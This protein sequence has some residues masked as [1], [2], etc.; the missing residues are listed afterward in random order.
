MQTGFVT[1]ILVG[2]ATAQ[3]NAY[4]GCSMELKDLF[5]TMYISVKKG[6]YSVSKVVIKANGGEAIARE[7]TVDVDDWSTSAS[8]TDDHCNTAHPH[9]LFTGNTTDT[10]YDRPCDPLARVHCDHLRFK[11]E[12]IALI[13]KTEP[14]TLEAGG[15]LDTDLMAGL[16]EPVDLLGIDCRTVQL[17]V[18]RFEHASVDLG[19]FGLYIRRTRRGQRRA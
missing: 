15:K 16:P 14:V 7:F 9:G 8:R 13:K 17:L 19:Q 18:E 4:E 1:P 12:D 6:H 3:L 2:K 11:G 5:C 10:R